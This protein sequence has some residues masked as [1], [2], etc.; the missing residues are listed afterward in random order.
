MRW[1]LGS[2]CVKVDSRIKSKLPTIDPRKDR[3]RR[4]D[5][6]EANCSLFQWGFF[7][8]PKDGMRAVASN[9]IDGLSISQWAIGAALLLS[10]SLVF[11]LSNHAR[12]VEV[13]LHSLDWLSELR[14]ALDS[15]KDK[16]LNLNEISEV[17]SSAKE[18][19]TSIQKGL[20]ATP[21]IQLQTPVAVRPVPRAPQRVKLQR[22]RPV[23]AAVKTEVAKTTQTPASESVQMVKSEDFSRLQA[24]HLL[25]RGRFIASVQNPAPLNMNLPAVQV[26]AAPQVGTQA[27]IPRVIKQAPRKIRKADTIRVARM[28]SHPAI[29]VAVPVMPSVNQKASEEFPKEKPAIPSAPAR[30]MSNNDTQLSSAPARMMGVPNLSYDLSRQ[31]SVT[32]VTPSIASGITLGIQSTSQERRESTAKVRRALPRIARKASNTVAS[33]RAVALN[34]H[35]NTQS[36]NEDAGSEG[37]EYSETEVTTHVE[38]FEWSFPVQG[39]TI[40]KFTS[41]GLASDNQGK[42]WRLSRAE[43]YWPTLSRYPSEIVPLI[44]QNNIQ[45]LAWRAKSAIQSGTGLVFGRLPAGW[46]ISLP[47]GETQP[48]L[49]N[50]DDT[51]A[52]SD[53]SGQKQSFTALNL[54]PGAQVIY[55]RGGTGRY[56]G[57]VVVPVFAGVGTYIDFSDLQV[58]EVSGRVLDG[59]TVEAL[60]MDGARVTA[61]GNPEISQ[62]D[63]QGYF[64]ISRVVTVPGHPVIFESESDNGYTHRYQIDLGASSEDV[65]L[66]RLSSN[67]VQNWRRQLER[68][69][70]PNSGLVVVGG[71]HDLAGMLPS[72]RTLGDSNSGLSPETYTLLPDGQ[73][74]V[75]KP[76]DSEL[77]RFVSVQVPDGMVVAEA[78]RK[79]EKPVWS[80]ILYTSRNVLNVVSPQ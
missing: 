33:G 46:E 40:S 58:R 43:D 38:A 29:P 50:S 36:Q 49:M 67:Q 44:S 12:K 77:P 47:D 80:E 79:G 76:L 13:N 20:Q 59:K 65:L 22:L 31:S 8:M 45:M 25:L 51:K 42:G 56:Q 1:S 23:P 9:A 62:T 27:P 52:G 18:H 73:L 2:S 19:A 72:V 61:F 15:G 34:T 16:G 11:S 64:R 37:A 3:E 69:I 7:A 63:R 54:R 5:K 78:S 32:E 28:S 10:S 48:L 71:F 35:V 39:A 53:S 70:S 75:Q 41:E 24:A 30:E 14:L 57:A 60:G 4:G 17:L 6:K 74:E 55:L 66:F 21:I 26:A 68:G